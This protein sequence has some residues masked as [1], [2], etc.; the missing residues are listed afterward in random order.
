M[1]DP[2]KINAWLE[3]H[4]FG[5]SGSGE[6]ILLRLPDTR[7]AAI[8]SCA[9]RDYVSDKNH[10]AIRYLNTRS[11]KSLAF[12]MLTHPHLDHY[13]GMNGYFD[14]FDV[15]NF[16]VSNAISVQELSQI[17]QADYEEAVKN[18]CPQKQKNQ[19]ELLNCYANWRKK[20]K[21]PP[22]KA[23]SRHTIYPKVLPKNPSFEILAF[24]PCEKEVEKYQNG[25]RKTVEDPTAQPSH[26]NLIS[27]GLIFK[28]KHF[29]VV[30]GGDVEVKN[31]EAALQIFGQHL[32][33]KLVKVSHHGSSNGKCDGLWE[34]FSEGQKPIAVVTGFAKYNLPD[35]KTITLIKQHAEAIFQTDTV[36][37]EAPRQHK[38]PSQQSVRALKKVFNLKPIDDRGVVLGSNN[39]FSSVSK[40]EEDRFGRCSFF[41][42]DRGDL[43]ASDLD[44]GRKLT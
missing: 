8:D 10:P 15:E 19:I 27:I 34:R 4:V 29:N 23:G 42:N 38:N 11:V 32:P 2:K 36:V 25:L 9:S 7:W 22:S 20:S 28:S 41:Y 6:A 40:K 44:G 13:W 24:S 33:S 17:V 18:S 35:P 26:F 5:S 1:V 43:L 30:L 37:A 21:G 12:V 16:F 39:G 14:D 3:V 31:W